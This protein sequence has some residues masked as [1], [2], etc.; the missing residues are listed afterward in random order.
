LIEAVNDGIDL[1]RPY[2]IASRGIGDDDDI[3]GIDVRIPA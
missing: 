2:V 1:D 3:A